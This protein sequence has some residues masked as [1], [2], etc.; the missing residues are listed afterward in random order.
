MLFRSKAIS[1]ERLETIGQ[2]IEKFNVTNGRLPERLQELE[3]VAQE[4]LQGLRQEFHDHIPFK[5]PRHEDQE[6]ISSKRK[7]D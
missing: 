7:K 6:K 3:Q 1:L 5:Q 2:A 4:K